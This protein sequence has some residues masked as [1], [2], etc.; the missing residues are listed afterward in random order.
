M[1]VAAEEEEFALALLGD[2]HPVEE[3]ADYEVASLTSIAVACYSLTMQGCTMPR[4]LAILRTFRSSL[5]YSTVSSTETFAIPC[6][7]ACIE[8]STADS[9]MEFERKER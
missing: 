9:P 2:D 4:C 3:E 7:G 8:I 5:D 6:G 1:T